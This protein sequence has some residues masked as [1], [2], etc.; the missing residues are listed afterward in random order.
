MNFKNCMFLAALITLTFMSMSASAVNS[1]NL[2]DYQLVGRYALPEPTRVAVPP[3]NLLAQEASAV[4]WNRDT[5]TLFI[6]GDGGKAVV[7]VGLTG[8]LID[9]MTLALNPS[10][11]QGVAFYDPEGLAYVG[12]GKFVLTQERFRIASQFT[13]TPNTTLAYANAQHVA[14]GTSIGNIGLEGITYDPSTSGATPGFVVVKEQAPM[15]VF[16]TNIDFA[17]GTATN[18][19]ATTVNSTN[20]FDPTITGLT[21]IADVFAFSNLNGI[22]ASESSHLLLLS[23]ELGKVIEVDR[24]GTTFSSLSIPFLPTNPLGTTVLAG[25]GGPLSLADQ[26]H[27]GLTMDDRGYLY[28][29]SENSGGDINNPQLWVLAPVPEPEAYAMMLAGLSVV[30]FAARR[31]RGA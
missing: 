4:T 23:Q 21:D 10:N 14:L 13:Y 11:P 2:A 17:A 25:T 15:G 8:N 19:S 9:S 26:Q 28:I 3:D 22:S 30:G 31:K 1:V 20:L 12:N 27:E 16:Q 24:N 5:N 7:Q 29:V 6:V 18:G